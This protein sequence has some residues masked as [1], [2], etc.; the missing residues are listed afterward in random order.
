MGIK[1]KE[2]YPTF[3]GF[4]NF[5]QK[6]FK[7]YTSLCCGPVRVFTRRGK[8]LWALTSALTTVEPLLTATSLYCRLTLSFGLLP[9]RVRNASRSPK[10]VCVRATELCPRVHVRSRVKLA[11]LERN[12]GL[13]LGLSPFT[14]ENRSVHGLGKC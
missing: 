5:R 2:T 7:D 1:K 12:I 4:P 13:N 6:G 10:N 3:K 14:L 9:T 8:M 11:V